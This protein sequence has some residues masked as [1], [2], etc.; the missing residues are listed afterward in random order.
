MKNT[1]AAAIAIG[2]GAVGNPFIFSEI[3]A[4]I[5]GEPYEPPSLRVRVDS[6]I[7]QIEYAASVHGEE[8]AVREARKQIALYLS[9]FRGAAAVRARIN[10]STKLDEVRAALCSVLDE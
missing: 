7:S 4:A 5:C 3:A 1:G 10:T 2:R 9:G 8:V 6:A